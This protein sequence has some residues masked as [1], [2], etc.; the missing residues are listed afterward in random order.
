MTDVH[1]TSCANIPSSGP[2]YHGCGPPVY[3]GHDWAELSH[4]AASQTTS[5]PASFLAITRDTIFGTQ[6][7]ANLYLGAVTFSCPV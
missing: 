7:R 5:F 3:G 1:S 2:G 6:H 4:H